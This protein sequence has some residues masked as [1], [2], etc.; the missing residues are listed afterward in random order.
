M[1]IISSGRGCGVIFGAY[2][3]ADVFK[4][5]GELMESGED[6]CDY[7][8][9]RKEKAGNIEKVCSYSYRNSAFTHL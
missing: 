2:N 1:T 6:V 5:Y 9:P 4:L 3:R 7:L 8:Q